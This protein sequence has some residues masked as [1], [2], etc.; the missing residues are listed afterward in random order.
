MIASA[1]ILRLEEVEIHAPQGP[2]FPPL[3]FALHAGDR[4]AL[5]GPS[6]VGKSSLLR[7]IL[8]ELPEGFSTTGMITAPP[9]IG[10]LP[11][12]AGESL[13]PTMAVG[14]LLGELVG[15]KAAR[16]EHVAAACAAVGLPTD[17]AFLRRRPWQLSG[18]EQRRIALARAILGGGPLLLLDEPTA[19]LDAR[20]RDE[21]LAWLRRLSCDVTAAML[22]VTHDEDAAT[23]LGCRTV[24]IGPPPAS[25]ARPPR[26]STPIRTGPALE[27]DGLRLRPRGTDL[28]LA[29]SPFQ[30]GRGEIVVLR[31]PSGCGKTTFLRALAGWHPR[32]EGRLRLEGAHLAPSIHRRSAQQR[33]A[34]QYVHQSPHDAFHPFRTLRRSLEEARP[35]FDLAELLERLDLAPTLLDR[36]PHELSGGQQQRFALIRAL[37]VGPRVL[38]LDEPTSALDARTAGR[39]HAL[40]R[41]T[42]DAEAG[43]LVI[44]HDADFPSADRVV[45]FAELAHR[46][47]HPWANATRHPVA[48]A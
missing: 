33:R 43:L 5:L 46:G 14:R 12:H 10:V 34:L 32:H 29:V 25:F 38:L 44:S 15:E 13:T 35:R 21:V 6:G 4:L 26:S 28:D 47:A 48:D 8:D 30:V 22:L 18:G 2:L 19:G 24:R 1:P 16:D 3:S 23:A 11:Q 39:V 37:S 42:A 9:R 20:S 27:V 7:A 45:D 31:G 36:L 40:L 17:R 41:D